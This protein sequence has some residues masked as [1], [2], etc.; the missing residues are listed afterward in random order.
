MEQDSTVHDKI[1]NLKNSDSSCLLGVMID[2][3]VG[4][5]TRLGADLTFEYLHRQE[6]LFSTVSSPALDAPSLPFNGY[7][8]SCQEI[9]WLGCKEDHFL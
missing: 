5:V 1:L 2:S 6:I 8:G 4:I 9:M 3:I 7:Q